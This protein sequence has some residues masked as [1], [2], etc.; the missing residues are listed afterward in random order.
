MY[1]K[2]WASIV[3]V[4]IIFFGFVHYRA[5]TT[6]S[7]NPTTQVFVVQEGD[8]IVVIGKNLA[9]ADLIANRGYFYYYTWKNK[10]RGKFKADNFIIEPNSTIAQIVHKLTTP[11]EAIVAKEKEIK[12]TFPEGWTIAKMAERL[13][14]NDL[15]GDDFLRITMDPPKTIYDE[16]PFLHEGASLEGY[17]FPDTYHFFKDATAENIITKMLTNFDVKI[18]ENYRTIIAS[19]NKDL[20]DIIIF[21][22]VIEGEVPSDADRS[23]VAGV[24]KNRLD[25]DMALQSD[26]TI[27]YIKGTPEIKHTQMDTEID[28]PYNTYK[29]PGL[30]PGPINNPSLASIDAAIAPAQ[31]DY[32]YFLNNVDTGETM[33]SKT[34]DEH[35]AKKSP[36]GL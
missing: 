34:F 21:A 15:P 2:K 19:Q 18:D 23:I 30:P 11:S 9:D 36:N 20:H 17:L 35:V 28:S 25:I 27:D 5:N 32:L 24:F 26:A 3:V 22:S 4:V 1:M 14:A 29:Y 16:F 31:T 7:Q 8:D 12:V 10:L 6:T 13:N 33:F